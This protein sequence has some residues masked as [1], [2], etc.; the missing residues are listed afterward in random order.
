MQST[1]L[2]QARPSFIAGEDGTPLGGLDEAHTYYVIVVDSQTIA[3]A[4]T[5]AQALAERSSLFAASGLI[6]TN[7][8]DVLDTIEFDSPHGFGDNQAVVYSNRGGVSVGGLTSEDVYYVIKKDEYRLQLTETP[9]GSPIALDDTAL[10]ADSEHGLRFDVRVDLAEMSRGFVS[11]DVA[12]QSIKFQERHGFVDGQAV[13]YSSADGI[14][15]GGLEDGRTYYVVN[16]TE[17]TLQL[18]EE[19]EGAAI[20]L[21][22]PLEAKEKAHGLRGRYRHGSQPAVR[23]AHRPR[24]FGRGGR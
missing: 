23:R 24:Y 13:V 17:N 12:N 3:L 14:D 21:T 7:D 6:D 1:P 22:V 2:P 9:N 10:A 4:P 11:E 18:A 19:S 8:N 15:L 20:S 16:A 5:Q